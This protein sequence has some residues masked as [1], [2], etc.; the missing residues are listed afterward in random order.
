MMELY[1]K[2][3]IEAEQKIVEYNALS[4]KMMGHV[5][6]SSYLDWYVKE[7]DYWWNRAMMLDT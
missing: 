3:C 5:V 2:L 6:P 4:R 1:L 7:R